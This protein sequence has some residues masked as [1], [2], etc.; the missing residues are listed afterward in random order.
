[1]NINQMF[2]DFFYSTTQGC[3]NMSMN[4]KWI[5]V[6]KNVK[7]SFTHHRV[8]L[9][10]VQSKEGFIWFKQGKDTMCKHPFLVFVYRL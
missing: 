4:W 7:K 3:A 10:A 5:D 6:M 9:I 1:M 2:E 8:A